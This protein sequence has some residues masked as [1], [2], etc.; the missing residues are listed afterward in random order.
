MDD[1]LFKLVK[2]DDASRFGCCDVIV[3]LTS[4]H[5]IVLCCFFVFQWIGPE[6]GARGYFWPLTA[7]LSSI[8]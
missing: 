3:I 1:N 5:K 4:R 2:I 8:T 7:N 6:F